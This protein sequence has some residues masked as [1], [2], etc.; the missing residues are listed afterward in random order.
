MPPSALSA[1]VLV[2]VVGSMLILPALASTVPLLVKVVGSMVSVEFV[3]LA[4]IVLALSSQINNM[5]IPARRA[6][7]AWAGFCLRGSSTHAEPF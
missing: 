4:E 3:P 5:T 2:K 1:P 6:A 7:S